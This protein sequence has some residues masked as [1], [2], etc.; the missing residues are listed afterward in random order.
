MQYSVQAPRSEP[1]ALDRAELRR[2][3]GAFPTG[4]T[5][6][7][8]LAVAG[9]AHAADAAALDD[10]AEPAGFPAGARPP[11]GIAASSF[12]SVSLDPPIVSVCVAHSSTTWPGLRR[13]PRL[14]ISVLAA[15]QEEACR[16]L[17]SPGLNRFA[18][19]RWRSSQAGAVFV[20]EASAW[21]ECSVE[22]EV[23]VGDHDVILLRVHE[24]DADPAVAPLVF[25]ASR[26]RQLRP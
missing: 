12:T 22:H 3:F 15:H 14:G 7:A 21:L 23:T 4:V 16:R 9:P 26:F 2:V 1:R 10:A 18:G 8:A 13:A 17:A 6:V 11:L 20:E 5:A 19:L 24:L 25:H